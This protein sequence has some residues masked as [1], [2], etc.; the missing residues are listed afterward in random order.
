MILRL[1]LS[2]TIVLTIGLAG[3]KQEQQKKVVLDVPF[4]TAEQRDQPLY[5]EFVG[6]VLGLSDIKIQARVDGLITGIHFTEG[7]LVKKDQLL[8][9]IDPLPYEA[10]VQQAQGE[11]AAA[12]SQLARTDADLK[13]IQPLAEINAVSMRE[14]DAARA[15]F[16][17]AKATV[18]AHG[19]SVQNRMIELG[20][21]NV[22]APITGII[23]LSNVKIGDYVSMISATALMNTVSDVEGIRVRFQVSEMDLL[24]YANSKEGADSS[25]SAAGK[26]DDVTIVLSNNEIYEHKGKL[27]VADRSIDPSTGS[28]KIEATFPNPGGKLR[29]GQFVR[30]RFRY[31]TRPGAILLPQRAISEMQGMFQVFIIDKDNKVKVQP[32]EVAEKVGQLWV[33][34]KGVTVSDR[35]AVLGNMFIPPGTVV[36]PVAQEKNPETPAAQ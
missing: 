27:N 4:I 17:A 23:G 24:K 18:S 7:T 12:R 3:C 1:L 21:C 11:L 9:T 6:E 20:Y 31:S 10:R 25:M 28:L 19:A 30:I 16:E 14:L 35:V 34:T 15:N 36:N 5:M 2:G 8:Y 32:V 26:I 29:P 22:T 13:R 33:V